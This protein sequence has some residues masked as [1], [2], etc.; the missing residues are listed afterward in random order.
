MDDLIKIKFDYSLKDIPIPIKKKY[1]IKLYDSISKFINTL[2][3]KVFFSNKLD[4]SNTLTCNDVDSIF[5]SKNSAPAC[6]ELKLFKKDLF[7]MA[8][9]IKFK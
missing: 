9:N 4:E 8:K 6:D 2:R 3:R 5:K 1:L 7:D